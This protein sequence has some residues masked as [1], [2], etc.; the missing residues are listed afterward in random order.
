MAEV[1]AVIGEDPELSIA[2]LSVEYIEGTLV[3]RG[4]A[5]SAEERERAGD[6]ARIASGGAPV[7]NRI[8]A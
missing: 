2:D 4:S 7:E 3:L 5:G 1:L 8:R 6:L